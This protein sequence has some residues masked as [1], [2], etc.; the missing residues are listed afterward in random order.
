MIYLNFVYDQI[1]PT[2]EDFKQYHLQY[3]LLTFF[4][5]N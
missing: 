2:M 3:E 1:G 4:C 5:I